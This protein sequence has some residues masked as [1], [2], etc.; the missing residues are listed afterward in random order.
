[1]PGLACGETGLTLPNVLAVCASKFSRNI[2]IK[3]KCSQHASKR[4]GLVSGAA[5]RLEKYPLKG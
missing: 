3:L 4:W 2:T 1:M 5:G